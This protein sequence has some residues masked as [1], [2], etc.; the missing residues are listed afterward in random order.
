MTLNMGMIPGWT[1][2]LMI[3][4]LDGIGGIE[5]T[6]AKN[7]HQGY[8]SRLCKLVDMVEILPM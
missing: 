7:G 3:W 4:D 2:R 5:G 6:T 8:G 1:S